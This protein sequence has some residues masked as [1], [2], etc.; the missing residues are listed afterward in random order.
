M[1]LCGIPGSNPCLLKQDTP[2]DRM[3][4]EGLDASPV[5]PSSPVSRGLSSVNPGNRRIPGNNVSQTLHVRG[6][7]INSVKWTCALCAPPRCTAEGTG[8]EG[9]FVNEPCT[10]TIF[11]RDR[12]GNPFSQDMPSK[13]IVRATG[14]PDKGEV[15]DMTTM[16]NG[17]VQVT[18]S[19]RITGTYLLCV[20]LQGQQINC[21]PFNITVL[22]RSES[23]NMLL[24]V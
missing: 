22:S 10:F 13:F 4:L 12:F 9:G 18:Y 6:S 7:P 19:L 2:Y 8:L 17:S 3:H 15:L 20:Q 11:P 5:L 14:G 21:S 1:I 23:E 16:E 24:R